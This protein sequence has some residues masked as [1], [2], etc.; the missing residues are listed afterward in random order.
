MPKKAQEAQEYLEL[1]A[2]LRKTVDQSDHYIISVAVP[3]RL[4][5]YKKLHL[6][7]MAKYVDLI[8]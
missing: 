8:L 7:D 5:D 2:A 1:L 6:A 4:D 3:A